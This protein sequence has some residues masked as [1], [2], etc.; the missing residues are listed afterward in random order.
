MKI[1]DLSIKRPVFAIVTSILLV[2]FGI[3]CFVKLPLR[4]Y[5]DVNPPIISIRTGYNGASAEIVESKITQPIEGIISGIEGIKTIESES[6]DG[7]STITIEFHINRDIDA[8][9]AD[10]RDRIARILN[11]LPLE[12]DAPE[13]TKLDTNTHEVIWLRISSERY[14]ALELTDFA[15]RDLVD[16]LAVVDGVARVRITGERRYAMRIWLDRKA[17]AARGLTVDDIEHALKRE[18]IELP[19]G[20]I[21]SYKREFTIRTKRLY[22]T[23]EDFKNLVVKRGDSDYLIRLGDV[24]EVEIGPEDKRTE[25]RANGLPAIGIGIAKQSRA[26][27]LEVARGVKKELERIT[28]TL[29][30]DI[31]VV[32]S[33]DGSLFIE[34]A[35]HEVYLTLGI[36]ILLVVAIIYIFLGNFRA[37]LIPALT[38]PI[39]L[40]SV[41]ILLYLLNYS[42]NLLTLLALV[43]AIG[44][45]VDDA[46]VVLENIYKKIEG[47]MQPLAA[48]Y[49]GTRQVR[50]AVIAT[51]LVLVAVFI[52]IA[53]LE[54]NVGKLFTEFALTLAGAVAFSSLIALT[55]CPMLCSKILQKTTSPHSFGKIVSRFLDRSMGPYKKSLGWSL[56]HPL[57]ISAFSLV[58]FPLIYLL[59]TTLPD[60]FEP[61]EDRGYFYTY[62][63]APEGSSLEYMKLHARKMEAGFLK[64]IDNQ[65]ARQTFVVIPSRY[66]STGS[67]NTG[68]GVVLLEP[69]EKRTRSSKAILDE[70][71]HEF[72]QQAGIQIIPILPKGLSLKKS[73]QPIQMVLQ[74]NSYE[75]LAK[76][77]DLFIEKIKTYPG[78]SNI[79]YDYKETKPQLLVEIDRDRAAALGVANE[80]IG[81]T[82]ETMLGSR[83][84]TSFIDKGEEY[85]VILQSKEEYRRTPGD[86]TGIYVRSA[87]APELVSIFNL[88]KMQ[89][90]SDAASLNRFNRMRSITLSG[91]I[92]AG[93]TIGPVLKYLEKAA[94]ELFPSSIRIDYKGESKMYRET[95]S[96]FIFVL[97]LALVMVYLVLAAQ[98]ESFIHPFIILTV[99]PLALLGGLWGLYLWGVTLNIYSQIGMI[100]LIGLS[101]KNS[102]LIV[103]FTNQ[104]RDEGYALLDALMEASLSRFRPILMTALSTAIGAIPLVMATGAGAE[105]RLSIGVVIFIGVF[106]ST[107]LT[108]Y[109]IPVFYSWMAKNTT[110]PEATSQELQRQLNQLE[111][112]RN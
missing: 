67:L 20:R 84:V 18:N 16:R 78:I 26:N 41:F 48:A 68:R 6:Q 43:L 2:L 80:V 81:R 71:S 57:L 4:E 32:V 109:V 25:L 56:K 51:T 72:S 30:K 82:L 89:E 108:L 102:I 110:S 85:F 46:I 47:G 112:E 13:I 105:S 40:I 104:L 55:L 59:F 52:P 1:S 64:L 63:K 45:V 34:S 92:G 58:A 103:E 74:G 27:T 90:T 65:E 23:A 36:T 9:A 29:P 11:E 106:L 66:S 14:N 61:L 101:A 69:W 8:A 28:P 15:D 54:G 17:L 93:Y 7:D 53:F 87:H 98:F 42:V 91:N 12:A 10:V 77:R 44:L 62:F 37:T 86:L 70:L 94:Q 3:L 100:M 76:W 33:Y 35:I 5:P 22:E 75:E 95:S 38:I 107:F 73:G 24:A 97:M 31:Q 96:S 60:E 88:V 49:L 50:F 21:E 83:K 39:S 79:D 99:V 19:A 111:K